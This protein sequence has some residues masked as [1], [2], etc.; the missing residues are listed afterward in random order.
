MALFLPCTEGLTSLGENV[1][2]RRQVDVSG[3]QRDSDYIETQSSLAPTLHSHPIDHPRVFLISH[4]HPLLFVLKASQSWLS[5]V[6]N[7]KICY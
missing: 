7:Q 6:S 4:L 1:D 2:V 5:V 3:G